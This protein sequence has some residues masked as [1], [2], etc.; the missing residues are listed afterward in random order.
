MKKNGRT[1]LISEKTEVLNADFNKRVE[2]AT[3]KY[4]VTRGS[5][6]YFYSVLVTKN[7]RNIRSTYLVHEFSFTDIFN[8]INYG[9]RAAILKK[10]SLWLLPF[11]MVVANYFYYEKVRRTMRTTIV[12]NFLKYFLQKQNHFEKW[13]R[14]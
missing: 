4:S 10:N 1:G 8:D 6:Q 13:S 7:R 12:S 14:K 3:G 11:Y 9:Y 2:A 5:L